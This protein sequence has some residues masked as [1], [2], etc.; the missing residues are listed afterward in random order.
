[1]PT[2]YTPAPEVERIAYELIPEYHKH[3]CHF[4]VRIKYLF[5]NDTPQKGGKLVW[6]QARKVTGLNAFLAG[7]ERE[8]G[9]IDKSFFVIVVSEKVWMT[10]DAKQKTALIDHELAHCWAEEN[11]KGELVL[12]MLEHDLNEFAAIVERYGNWRKD[13][14]QFLR[15]AKRHQGALEFEDDGDD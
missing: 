5:R 3:L 8:D 7:E 10:L 13:I 12:S 1:M 6:A 4:D 14:E 9:A 11:D 15:A 2:V